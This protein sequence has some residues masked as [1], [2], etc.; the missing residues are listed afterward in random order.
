MENDSQAEMKLLREEITTLKSALA[1]VTAQTQALN[2]LAQAL[3]ILHPEPTA[4][5]MVFEHAIPEANTLTLPRNLSEEDVVALSYEREW[6][7]RLL[8]TRG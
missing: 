6:I 8:R 1:S 7:L 2:M 4:L 3:V 5:L